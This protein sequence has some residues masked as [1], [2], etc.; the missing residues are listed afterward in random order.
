MVQ[1]AFMVQGAAVRAAR[2]RWWQ[3]ALLVSALMLLLPVS[4]AFAGPVA[5]IE[6]SLTQP[7]GTAIVVTPFGDEWYSGY[8]YQGY[9]ILLEPVSGYW[10]YARSGVGGALIPSSWRA[11]L[12][13]PAADLPLHLRDRQVM[14]SAVSAGSRISPNKWAGASGTQRV[15]VIL[16]DFNPSTSRGTTEAQWNQLFFDTTPGAKSVRNYYSQAS[17]SQFD[18]APATE[19]YGTVNDGVIAVTL[20][21]AH[22][23][24]LTAQANREI[25]YNALVAANPYI[26]YSSLDTNGNGALDTGEVHLMIIVRGYEESYGGT[27]GA[28]T[29]N[30]WGHRGSLSSTPNPPQLDGVWVAAY[31]YG[32]GYTQEGEWHEMDDP[33]T[34]QTCGSEPDGHMATMGI[35]VHELGHDIDW[36]DL[37]DTDTTDG[38]DSAGVGNWSIM[39]G[40]SWG[41]ASGDSYSGQTPVLPDAF[42]KWYQG[43]ISPTPVTAPTTGIAIPN[44]AQNPTAYL[45]GINTN[46]FD[47]DFRTTSGAGEYFL[48]ENRQQQGFDAGLRSISASAN[49]CL[50]Y[51]I[52]ETRTSANTANAIPERKLVDIEEADGT[53]QDLDLTTGGNNGDSGDPWPGSTVNTTFDAASTPNSNWYDGSTSGIAVT[54]ISTAGTG[55]TVDFSG[56]G[57]TWTGSTNS[58]WDGAA[59]WTT[60]RVPNQNDNAVIPSGV[61]NWPNV[62]V[63]SSVGNLNILN[64][65]HLDA[66]NDVALNVYGNWSEVGVGYFNATAGTVIFSGSTTQTLTAGT[67]TSHFHNLQI[68]DGAT[69]QT[70]TASSDLDVNGNVTIQAGAKL[71]ADAYTINVGGNWTDNPFGFD[72]GTG[73]V[74]F[75]GTTQTIQRAASEKMVYSND[76][77]DTTGWQAVDANSDS[78][79]WYSG[80]YAS[81][82]NIPNQGPNA[83]YQRNGDGTTAADDWLFTS[84][85]TLQ[86]GVAYTI[87]FDYGACSGYTER[88]A[89]HVG[90]AQSVGAMTNQVFDNGN[91]VNTTWQQGSGTFTPS[92]NG[93][94]YLGFHAYSAP[95]QM[96]VGIDNVTVVASEPDL[97]FYDLEIA[98]SD[99]TTLGDNAVI[100]SN[101]TVNSG[102]TLTLDT[103]DVSVEGTVTNDGRMAQTRPV[104]VGGA[105][106]LHIQDA[107][108]STDKYWGAIVTPAGDMGATTVVIGG[109][110]DCTTNTNDP[111]IRRC[112]NINPTTDQNAAIR[113]YFTYDELNGRTFN[114]LRPWHWNPGWT[115]AGDTFIHSATC[116]AGQQDCWMEA[117]NISTYSPFGLGNVTAPTAINLRSLTANPI[118]A[119]GPIGLALPALLGLTGGV[120]IWKQRQTR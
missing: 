29:P 116:D 9:T 94:Y 68:G 41:W 117:Q 38:S 16:T 65:A 60:A 84:G 120:L 6:V 27:G 37:Y 103:Y 7:N 109:N 8:E 105:T 99:T 77:S 1:H 95:N 64:G 57:P 59:N 96:R 23:Y 82:P 92:S 72:P 74:I 76:L 10:V 67:N 101:L 20:N 31:A 46:G 69:S 81:C 35:M 28:C 56:T 78:V 49:G 13:K 107:A 15:L 83:R 93:V 79:T 90:A 55:C 30:V 3:A 40:G 104:N 21:Y 14:Q 42:L 80:N 43:W 98:G 106:F 36:P 44:S 33:G 86:A 47:W 100:Q 87:R 89:A 39:A 91:I 34:P 2:R 73:V 50:I 32:G 66:A 26:D 108:A 113:F 53:P 112:F 48:I 24:P 58:N 61:S 51:H 111:L 4:A 70:V 22:P 88:L 11:G 12:D 18:L 119:G 25:S 115:Q 85:F 71:A 62:N 102:V 97:T 19:S 54:N 63:A 114:T 52:D 118:D 110:Q 17:F 5:P 75:D 45:L